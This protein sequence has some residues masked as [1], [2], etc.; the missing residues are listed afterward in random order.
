MIIYFIQLL[1]LLRGAQIQAIAGA[2]AVEELKKGR[3]RGPPVRG[4]GYEPVTGNS[5]QSQEISRTDAPCADRRHQVLKTRTEHAQTEDTPAEDIPTERHIHRETH[6]P[7]D[8]PTENYTHR[9][10]Y[11]L[12]DTPIERYIH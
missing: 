2:E 10:A 9:Q 6:P 7:R 5:W 3:R 11:A 12:R 1:P 4:A 8:T